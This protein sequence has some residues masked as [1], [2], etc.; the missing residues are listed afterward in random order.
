MSPLEIG[1]L[2][3]VVLFILLFSGLPIGLG[4]MVVGF[5]GF[6]LAFNIDGAL[7][8]LRT[9]P[10]TTFSD[11][12]FSVIPLFILMGS[13]AFVTQL[14]EDL[15]SAAHGAFGG[16]RGGLAMATIAACGAFA[17][18]SGSSVAT[19]A[20]MGKVALPEMKRYQYD[21]ALATGSVAAGGTIGI[22]IPPSVIFIIYGIITEQSIGRLYMAGFL[23]GVLQV[24]MFIIVVAIVCWLNPKLGP[25]SPSNTLL[26]KLKSMTK[27]W[28]ALVLFLLVIG[29]IYLRSA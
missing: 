7:G 5:V 11:Y 1:L 21:S 8:V 26:E 18:I 25:A 4:F 19:A 28:S 17:A 22:L 27:G 9:V 20:T 15:Y 2:G 23:P 6:A 13:F 3:I 10:Y 12:N 14:S 29:G 16:V 24:V